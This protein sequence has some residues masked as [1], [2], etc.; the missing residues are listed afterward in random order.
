MPP[1][2][3]STCT[4]SRCVRSESPASMA[5]RISRCFHRDSYACDDGGGGVLA[6]H[7]APGRPMKTA[8]GAALN[9]TDECC[10]LRC[11]LSPRPHVFR[12]S[13]TGRNFERKPARSNRVGRRPHGRPPPPKPERISR[14]RLSLPLMLPPCE[15]LG[16]SRQKQTLL[17]ALQGRVP[18][19]TMFTPLRL[20]ARVAG[21]RCDRAQCP[22]GGERRQVRAW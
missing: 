1:G 12:V 9:S 5:A 19:H 13:V 18:L 10:V 21:P 4:S 3:Q 8:G 7:S 11:L 2:N 17:V 20:T 22:A 6:L 16:C 14:I 15:P